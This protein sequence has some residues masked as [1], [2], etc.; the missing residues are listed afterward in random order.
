MELVDCEQHG[1][2]VTNKRAGDVLYEYIQKD[3]KKETF[4]YSRIRNIYRYPSVSSP[5]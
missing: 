4:L 5:T 1:K 3:A 2:T